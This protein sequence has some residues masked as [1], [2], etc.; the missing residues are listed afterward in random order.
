MTLRPVFHRPGTALS[1][2]CRPQSIP[3]LTAHG[4]LYQTMDVG[5]EAGEFLVEVAREFQ[6]FDDRA[7]E[8]LARVNLGRLPA[9]QRRAS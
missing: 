5:V 9:C 3:Q 8:T 2:L 6:V 4:L 1:Y 7:V